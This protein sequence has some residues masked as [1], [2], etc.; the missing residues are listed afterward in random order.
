VEL[1]MIGER[2]DRHQ[3]SC[4]RRDRLSVRPDRQAI[5]TDGDRGGQTSLVAPLSDARRHGDP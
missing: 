1:P 4:E 2:R 3:R 5:A